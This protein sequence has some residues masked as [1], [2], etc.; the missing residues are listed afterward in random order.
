MTRA[1][2]TLTAVILGTWIVLTGPAWGVFGADPRPSAFA[3]GVNWLPGVLTLGLICWSRTGNPTV[4]TA[5]LL[6]SS[7]I[8]LILSVVGG[9][10]GWYLFPYLRGLALDLVVWGGIFYVVTLVTES[11]LVHRLVSTQGGS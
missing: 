2:L 3:A 9:G 8:R 11:M 7:F 4:Q 5:T 10:L 1:T 6:A